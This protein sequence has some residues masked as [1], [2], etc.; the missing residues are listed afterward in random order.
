MDPAAPV[1]P[2]S[3]ERRPKKACDIVM[4]GGITSGVVYPEAVG[5]LAD[6]YEFRNIGGASAGAISCAAVSPI[7]RAPTPTRL[8]VQERESARPGARWR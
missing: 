8:G 3:K 4:K 2:P 6:T 7:A 5:Q 1:S